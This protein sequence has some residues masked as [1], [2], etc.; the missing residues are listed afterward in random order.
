MKLLFVGSKDNLDLER[1]GGI[2]SVMRRLLD[3]LKQKDFDISVLVID[4]VHK[5]NQFYQSAYGKIP[6]RTT[7][8]K[9]ARKFL[10]TEK[11]DVINFLKTPFENPIFAL[12]FLFVKFKSG[13][14]TTKLFFTYPT[15]A[16]L[17]FL[18]KLKLKLLIDETFLFS[19]RLEK[20]IRKFNNNVTFLYPPVSERFFNKKH[21]E[22]TSQKK[23]LFVGRI[24]ADKG[25]EIVIDVFSNLDKRYFETGIVG[26]FSTEEDK[27]KY[28]KKIKNL[29]A[30]YIQIG[31]RKSGETKE[32]NLR[33]YDILLLPY[34]DLS[35]TLDTPLLLLEGLASGCKIVTSDIEPINEIKGNIYF[36]EDYKNSAEF[37]KITEEIS[38][39]ESIDYN[40]E[41]S[42]EKVGANYLNS[43]AK[44]N[45]KVS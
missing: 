36:V 13:T 12:K 6:I 31:E 16:N 4:S 19:K 44:H 33:E 42:L 45:V 8:V 40:H 23:I 17:T 25:I 41:F 24:S 15:V 26:Y 35:P 32:L 10:L 2:E 7:D 5:E 43:L 38:E 20:E 39:K 9:S 34:Q 29:N 11:F 1:I 30:D 3:F 28:E 21:R 37:I 18:Q 14:I 27:E 22:K